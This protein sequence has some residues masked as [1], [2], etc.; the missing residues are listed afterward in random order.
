MLWR[1]ALPMLPS[2]RRFFSTASVVLPLASKPTASIRGLFDDGRCGVVVLIEIDRQHA[3]GT[4]GEFQPV[5]VVV[6][7]EDVFG[8]QQPGAGGGHQANRARTVDGQTAARPAPGVDHRLITGEQD[9]GEKQHLLV[10]QLLGKAERAGVGLGYPHIFRLTAGHTAVEV[11]VAEQR[12]PRRNLLLVEDG[13]AV[14]VGGFAGGMQIH[15]AEEAAAAGDDEGHQHALALA[16]G[17]DILAGFHHLAEEFMAEDVAVLH[18]G[19]RAPVQVQVR[20]ADRGGGDLQDDIVIGDDGRIGYGFHSNV[21]T[22]VIGKCAHAGS[23]LAGSGCGQGWY[24]CPGSESGWSTGVMRT[25][26][27]RP[28][29]FTSGCASMWARACSGVRSSPVLLTSMVVGWSSTMKLTRKRFSCM[30]CAP[31]RWLAGPVAISDLTPERG[32]WVH[33]FLS[34][35]RRTGVAMPELLPGGSGHP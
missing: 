26:V 14:G 23:S 33:C 30:T 1:S 16:D 27:M 32:H 15:V 13:T 24:L 12:G 20:T 7:H 5:L 11:A 10:I 31:L 2:R 19:D 3:V 22:A 28:F 17:G 6:H 9:I 35:P 21:V 25:S 8:T 18:L 4:R 29:A 34:S